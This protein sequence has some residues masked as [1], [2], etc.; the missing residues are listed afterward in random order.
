MAPVERLRP[1]ALYQPCAPSLFEFDTTAKV[2]DGS[3]SVG[4][5]RRLLRCS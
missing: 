2:Q 3:E 5:P 1:E 4:Q